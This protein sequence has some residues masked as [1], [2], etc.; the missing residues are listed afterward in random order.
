M[1][2]L[3]YA[4]HPL[5][6]GSGKV[7]E[8]IEGFQR[9]PRLLTPLRNIPD[10]WKTDRRVGKDGFSLRLELICENSKRNAP[11]A[12][13]LAACRWAR[14]PSLC[15]SPGFTLVGRAFP[16][17]PCHCPAR[18]LP[19]AAAAAVNAQGCVRVPPCLSPAAALGQQQ[20]LLRE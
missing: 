3:V 9:F 7:V 8:P 15:G 1:L 2:K 5:F 6:T 14:C 20:I 4:I 16:D 10:T 19:L 11:G 13:A 17:P 18:L 12:V